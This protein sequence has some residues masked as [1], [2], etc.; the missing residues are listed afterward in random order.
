MSETAHTRRENISG[1]ATAAACELTAQR[2][3]WVCAPGTMLARAVG[4]GGAKPQPVGTASAASTVAM[5][6]P[7]VAIYTGRGNA[8]MRTRSKAADLVKF[9]ALSSKKNGLVQ[10]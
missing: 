9:R 2:W 1:R 3:A 6:T 5:K 8:D 7:L 4:E 10:S